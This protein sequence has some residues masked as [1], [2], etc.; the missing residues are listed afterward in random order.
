M[1]PDISSLIRSKPHFHFKSPALPPNSQ[2]LSPKKLPKPINPSLPSPSKRR[3]ILPTDETFPV[4]R[5][6]SSQKSCTRK[7]TQ[8]IPIKSMPEPRRRSTILGKT[9]ALQ[10]LID[11]FC[12]NQNLLTND[13]PKYLAFDDLL[14]KD[15]FMKTFEESCGVEAKAIRNDMKKNLAIEKLRVGNYRRKKMRSLQIF[16]NS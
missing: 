3:L 7:L 10:T 9:Q 11:N 13:G 4:N 5:D 2:S 16:N 14:D 15:L 8:L 1:E 6:I 12:D